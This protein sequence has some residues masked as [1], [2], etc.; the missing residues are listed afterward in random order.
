MFGETSAFSGFSVDDLDAARRFYGETLGLRVGEEGDGDMRMLLLT[1]ADGA[2]I[3]VY[4][5]DDHTPATFTILNFAV[6]DIDRAV[7]ELTGRGVTLERYDGFEADAK[8]VVRAEGGPPIAWFKDP[9]GNVLA[10]L[11]EPR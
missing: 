11:Q 4:P 5:K 1:L 6:D 9:A 2:R 7:D 10:V 8:G 3:F